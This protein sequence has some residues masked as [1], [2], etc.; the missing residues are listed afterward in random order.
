M[1]KPDIDNILKI[2]FDGLNAVAFTDDAHIVH[3]NDC[4]KWYSV[5]PRVEVVLKFEIE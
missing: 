5:R 3:L 1:G 2:I 4:G